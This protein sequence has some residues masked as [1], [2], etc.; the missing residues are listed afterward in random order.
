M[1]STP[2]KNTKG[3]YII[4]VRFYIIHKKIRVHEFTVSTGVTTIL[5]NWSEQAIKG[6]D[7]AT[8]MKNERLA[9]IL[10]IVKDSLHDLKKNEVGKCSKFKTGT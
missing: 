9:E 4:Y 10:T 5:K 3:N 2:K 8:Q 6:K 7:I 1:F